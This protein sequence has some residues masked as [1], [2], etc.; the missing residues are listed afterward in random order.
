MEII[1]K[2]KGMI[3]KEEKKITSNNRWYRKNQRF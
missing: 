1:R 2:Y 3:L